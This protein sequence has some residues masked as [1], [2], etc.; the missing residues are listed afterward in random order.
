MNKNK[1]ILIRNIYH[2]LSYAFTSLRQSVF[3]EIEKEEFENI[4][5]LFASV[6]T[7]G[8]GQQLKQGLYREYLSKVEALPVLRGKIDLAGTIKK[9]LNRQRL[10]SCEYDELSENNYLNQI[11]KTTVI[12]L[13]KHANVDNK[14]KSAL[15][16]EMLYFSNVDTVD[17]TAIKWSA[18][19]FQRSNQTYQMLIN[20][21]Q[22]I[23]EGMLLTTEQGKYKLASFI[24]EQRMSR[25][26]EKFILEYYVKH[27]PEL[28]AQSQII[29]WALD[30]GMGTMLPNMQSDITLS[31]ANKILIIDAK[32]YSRTLQT[33]FD[34]PTVHSN[35]LYQMFAYVKNKQAEASPLQRKVS[36]LILY[37][38]TDELT[39]PDHTYE[40]SG[41][42]ITVKTLD[43]NQDFVDIAAQLDSLVHVHFK[44][45]PQ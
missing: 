28:N 38:R 10:L 35:N 27:F 33:H 36:G 34:T 21:C 18:I 7:K 40:M 22:L 30:D 1:H 31:Y 4:H 25:L 13:L 42:R 24:D 26:Y 12:I 20:I 5:N 44:M 23:L 37:A 3:E 11:L 32:F 16:K 6:L 41:N 43:L 29:R 14:Y 2:M 39:Q 8:I 19:R 17:P 45:I 15:R 9:Q